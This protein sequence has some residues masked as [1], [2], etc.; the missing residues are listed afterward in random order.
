MY[1]SP[2]SE[3]AVLGFEFGYSTILVNGLTLWEAQFGDFVNGAQV[4]I[5]QFISSSEAKWGQHSNLTLLLPHGYEGQGPEHSSARM[6][7]FL[8]LCAENNMFVCNFTTPAQYFHALRR[9]VKAPYRKPMIVM[10]PKEILRKPISVLNDLLVPSF[11]EIINDESIVNPSAIEKVLLCSGKVYYDLIA[12]RAKLNKQHSVAI[13][14]VEQLYPFRDDIVGEMLAQ[15]SN[16]KQVMWVQ[17]EPKNQGSWSFI[18]P[19]LSDILS[20]GQRLSYAGR[21]EAA[22]PATVFGKKH[23]YEKHM[24]LATAFQ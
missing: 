13:I 9:Q 7:R 20:V 4:V 8:Q 19:R 3:E 15:Y 6:E 17:E 21:S 5:D 16:A 14:R 23:E 2:L 22:S 11:K 10:S 18:A 12:E 1:N 24:F